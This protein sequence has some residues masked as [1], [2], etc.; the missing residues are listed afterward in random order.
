MNSRAKTFILILILI[1]LATFAMLEYRFYLFE[2]RAKLYQ[3]Y[4]K[5]L[6]NE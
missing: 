4:Y 6:I 1:Y 2:H 5:E 3:D